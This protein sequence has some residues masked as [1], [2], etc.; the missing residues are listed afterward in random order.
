VFIL[1]V[2]ASAV[3]A[4]WIS[5]HGKVIVK[6]LAVA[7]EPSIFWDG[8][9][10]AEIISKIRIPEKAGRL[11]APDRQF[12][13]PSGVALDE[14]ILKPLGLKRSNA[15]L[16]DLVP[17]SCLNPGQAKA[18]KAEYAPLARKLGLPIATIQPVPKILADDGRR[19]E[20]RDEL[21]ESRAEILITLGDQPLRW[22]TTPLAG[23][24]A[25]LAGFEKTDRAYGRLHPIEI[26]GHQF[27]LLPLAHP[28][29]IRQLGRADSEW[30]RIHRH[31]EG[32]VAPNLL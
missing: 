13:G 11:E 14:C 27:Q 6:A 10:A 18:I 1:G 29:Q 4:R 12:N 5:V 3:H 28:R 24:K 7:S 2:Y 32:H 31:W 8:S 15:W 26:A 19:R 16:S 9:D 30:A 23:T 20:I 21:F 25:R 17:Y 22:F